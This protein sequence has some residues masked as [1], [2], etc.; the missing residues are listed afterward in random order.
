ML[1]YRADT[2]QNQWCQCSALCF[3]PASTPARPWQKPEASLFAYVLRT[4]IWENTCL[5]GAAGFTW[6]KSIIWHPHPF[7]L[8][9]SY[10]TTFLLFR[11]RCYGIFRHSSGSARHVKTCEKDRAGIFPA[12][13]F[14]VFLYASGPR[15]VRLLGAHGPGVLV[16]VKIGVYRRGAVERI[17]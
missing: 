11:Q 4:G 12:R 17:I 6:S 14:G 8:S 2:S 9:Y 3:P 13:S 7:F 5:S 10:N 16:E 1:C 15:R